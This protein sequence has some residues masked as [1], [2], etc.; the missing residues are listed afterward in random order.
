M[1]AIESTQ[2]RIDCIH[3]V[4]LSVP[5]NARSAKGRDRVVLLSRYARKALEVSAAKSNVTLGKL[6][7]DTNGAPLPSDGSY[8][9]LT[10][11]P[12]YVGA[13][14]A[15]EPTGI[16]IEKIRKVSAAVVRKITGSGELRLGGADSPAGFFRFWTAKEAVLKA[17]GVGMKGLSSCRVTRIVDE[18]HLEAEYKGRVFSIEQLYFSEH[19]AAVVE[20]GFRVEWTVLQWNRS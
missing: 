7:K 8:W 13:V 20:N 16:D 19:I 12:D 14:V 5:E 6:L 9:S 10:H 2:N 15:S 17:A 18:T 11:K 4:I 3:P 1:N